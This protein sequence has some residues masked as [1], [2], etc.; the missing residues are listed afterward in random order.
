MWFSLGPCIS[1]LELG[2]HYSLSESL[3]Q[4]S[5]GVHPNLRVTVTDSLSTSGE[6]FKMIE[7]AHH[8][9][10]TEG[11]VK[12]AFKGKIRRKRYAWSRDIVCQPLLC[13]EYWCILI[14]G[15]SAAMSLKSSWKQLQHSSFCII[16]HS[17]TLGTQSLH[18][19]KSSL[20]SLTL[21]PWS[22]R[23]GEIGRASCRERV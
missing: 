10:Q 12:S 5:N 1:L 17:Y 15:V 18:S 2:V 23:T 6:S 20:L 7:K 13:V 19:W 14:W 22:T 3:I 8:L 4:G 16:Q 11:A 21:L 9:F